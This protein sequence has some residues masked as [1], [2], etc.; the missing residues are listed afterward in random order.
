MRL[1]LP[2]ISNTLT[3]LAK[4]V[5]IPLGIATALSATDAAIQ[6]KIFELEQT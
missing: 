4:T 1:D 2:L 3:Q 6:K 5:S